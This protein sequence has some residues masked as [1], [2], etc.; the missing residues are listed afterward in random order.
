MVFR[1]FLMHNQKVV[2]LVFGIGYFTISKLFHYP[3]SALLQWSLLHHSAACIVDALVN[4]KGIFI[5]LFNLSF[6]T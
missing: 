6:E 2:A 3:I 1:P 4:D 5:D